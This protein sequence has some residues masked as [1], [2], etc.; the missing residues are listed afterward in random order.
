MLF[1]SFLAVRPSDC[2]VVYL[3]KSM[4]QRFDR[5][6]ISQTGAQLAYFFL[7]SLSPFLIFFN[8]LISALNIKSDVI[9]AQLA[10]ILPGQ[11]MDIIADY[12][13][14]ALA[15]QNAALL[16]AGLVI[17][18]YSA[19][20]AVGALIYAINRAYEIEHER[21]PV[22]QLIMSMLFTLCVAV[23]LVL[24]VLLI[25]AGTNFVNYA[26]KL[27]LISDHVVLYIKLTSWAIGLAIM[28][29]I[30]SAIYYIIPN[31]KLEYRS[32]L[33]GVIFSVLSLTLF[34]LAFSAYINH[35][36]SF[37]MVYGSTGAVII[38][39]LWLYFT[40]IVLVAGAEINSI[41][42]QAPKKR[43]H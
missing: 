37:S 13:D 41:L 5:H 1:E 33:P 11:I 25:T 43:R 40:G 14:Y 7:L 35:F 38:L 32:V 31:K 20:R 36:S 4:I 18:L 30:I 26:A 10:P 22:R 8:A 19:S 28:F 3:I 42:E 23:I 39:L 34:T 21:K 6:D 17:T 24:T 27:Y 29:A 12:S 9:F 16:S 15:N 2:L